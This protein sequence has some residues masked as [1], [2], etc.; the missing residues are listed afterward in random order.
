MKMWSHRR[1][2]KWPL[3]KRFSIPK[4]SEESSSLA[5][6]HYPIFKFLFFFFLGPHP[7]NMEAPR[8]G[9]GSGLQVPAYATAMATPDLSHV[10]DLH[11]S[12]WQCWIL[13]PLSMAGDWTCILMDSSQVGNLLSHNRNSPIFKI[14][15]NSFSNH[16]L[17]QRNFFAKN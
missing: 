6:L 16:W 10:Y 7:W 17:C 15:S 9:I 12:S 5:L 11:C 3:P 2:Q 8:L 4:L 13:N 1:V 14:L